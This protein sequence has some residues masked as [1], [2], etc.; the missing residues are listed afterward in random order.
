M[1]IP[2]KQQVALKYVYFVA[3]C[4]QVNTFQLF[5]Q[6]VPLILTIVMSTLTAFESVCQDV[7]VTHA[8]VVALQSG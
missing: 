2:L 4:L 8:V 6:K 7:Y 1:M 3:P 5:S